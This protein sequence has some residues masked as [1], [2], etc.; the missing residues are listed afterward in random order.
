MNNF[1]KILSGIDFTII[2]FCFLG[3]SIVGFLISYIFACKK[4]LAKGQLIGYILFALSLV[5]IELS[6]VVISP[7][8]IS[9][10]IFSVAFEMWL[11]IPF[12]FTRKKERVVV[13]KEHRELIKNSMEFIENEKS[14]EIDNQQTKSIGKENTQKKLLLDFEKIL[15]KGEENK[16]SR[17]KVDKK[18]KKEN[19]LLSFSNVKKAIE[20]TMSKN[21]TESEKRQ[22]LSLEFAI[23]QK[24]RGEEN[25]LIKEQVNE[26]LSALLKIMS[27]YCV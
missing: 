6:F 8:N 9:L 26:G 4:G 14:D 12:L 7:T 16:V 27:K 10:L 23:F 1:L 22:V 18:E 21:L 11:L 13:E 24:E 3:L 19:E 15:P 17:V 20:K 5:L 25:L 2:L